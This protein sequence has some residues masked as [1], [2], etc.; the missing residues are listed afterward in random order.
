M[1]NEAINW[2]LTL[3]VKH[4]T[5]KFVLVVL[6]NCADG[7]TWKAWPSVA[8]LSEATGQD[9]KTVIENI[10]RLIAMGHIHDTGER[11]GA[12]GQVPI[13]QLNNAGNGTVKESQKRNSTENGTV[14]EFPINS[15]EIPYKES[16]FS[17]VTVPKTGHGTQKNHKEP[18]EPKRPGG[19]NVTLPAW[20]PEQTWA[21]WVEYRKSIKAALSPAAA[22]LCIAKL[23]LLR[24]QG[25]DPVTVVENSIMSGKWTGFYAL[26]TDF[27]TARPAAPPKKDYL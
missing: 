8:H 15:T 21:D 20:L 3:P 1:S 24:G 9:R 5:A 18:K 22:K 12:T 2:A 16:R 17:L 7:D 25:S 26:K 23:D 13:Y 4:S 6:A 19:L 14:P 27:Q 10:K 11:K